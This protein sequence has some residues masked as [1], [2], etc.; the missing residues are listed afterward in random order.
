MI[1]RSRHDSALNRPNRRLTSRS[2]AKF[3]AFCLFISSSVLT[4]SEN[5][6]G[7]ALGAPAQQPAQAPR[8]A[9]AKV[10][11]EKEAPLLEPGKAIKRELSGAGSHTYRIKLAA[12]QFMNAVIEQDGIDV[13][14][15]LLGP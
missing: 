2:R 3:L 9:G 4:L 10:D 12:D 1:D 6:L 11:D 7:R 5:A 8:D 15:R 14:A 13:V